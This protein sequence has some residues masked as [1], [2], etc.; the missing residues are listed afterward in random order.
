MILRHLEN[1]TVTVVLIGAET[2]SR[3]WV[4]FEIQESAKRKNGF[5]G[6]H[7]H[8]LKD[9]NHPPDPRGPVPAV[10]AGVVFPTY[11]WDYNLDKFRLEIEAAGKRSDELRA[12][13]RQSRW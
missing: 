7:I 2:A 9:P 3:P 4:Q 5:L 10:P 8:H 11:D 1:T 13:T 6:V 12:P